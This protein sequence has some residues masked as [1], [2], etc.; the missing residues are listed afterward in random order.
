[1]ECLMKMR[2][3]PFRTLSTVSFCNGPQATV[4]DPNAGDPCCGGCLQDTLVHVVSSEPAQAAVVFLA[5]GELHW[6]KW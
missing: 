6:F 1:M 5:N 2:P 3:T 4:D